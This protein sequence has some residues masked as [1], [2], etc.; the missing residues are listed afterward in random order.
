MSKMHDKKSILFR[1][2]EDLTAV[3]YITNPAIAREDEIKRLILTLVMPEK[4]AILVGKP[5]IGKTAIVEGLAYLIQKDEVPDAIKN[6]KIIKVNITSLLGTTDVAGDTITKVQA[7]VDELEG[8]E[9]TIVFIDEIHNIIGTG[10][11]AGSLDFANMLKPSLGRGTIK[12]IGATTTEEFDFYIIKDRPFLRRFEKIEIAEP[13][14]ETSVKI[15]MGSIPKIEKKTGVKNEYSDFTTELIVKFMVNMTSE[16]KR[17]FEA[18]SKYP[19]ITLA[20]LGKAFSYAIYDN[21]PVLKFKHIW[22]AVRN[23]ESIYPDSLK[24]EK[25]LFKVTFEKFIAEE[26]VDVHEINI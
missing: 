13:D 15:I 24:K 26:N 10:K 5:G 21:S 18:T 25:E 4:S 19:D 22:E 8:E 3:E 1:Y 14:Q 6:F 12:L 20:L 17:I 2:G 11:G 16:Y 9:K 7:L 23:C